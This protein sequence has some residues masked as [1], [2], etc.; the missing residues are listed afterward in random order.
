MISIIIPALNE[1]RTIA[2]VVA[3]CT[4]HPQV[5]EVVV[6]DD[7]SLDGTAARARAAG[8]K[9]ITSTLLGK[10]ASMRDGLL[11]AANDIIVFLDGDI[12]PYP[13]HTIDLLARS[14]MDGEADFVKSTFKRSAGR[15]TE[16]VAKPLLSMFFPG[17]CSFSQPLS[18]MIAGRREMF[19]KVNLANDY[20]VDIGILIDMHLQ[21][22]RIKEVDI[23]FI[24]NDSQPLQELGIMS[25]QVASAIIS[26]ATLSNS[27]TP[28]SFQEYRN[29]N[30]IRDQMELAFREQLVHEGKMV[31]FDMDDTILRGRFINAFTEKYGYTRQLEELRQK[32]RNP[33]ILTKAIARLLKGHHIGEL[34]AI[35]DSIPLVDDTIEVV[36]ELKVKGY[37]VGLITDSYDFVANHVKH[38]I[39]ADFCLANEAE[40]SKSV[41]TGEVKVPSFFFHNAESTC[42]HT[43]CKSNALKHVLNRYSIIHGNCIAVGDSENDICM[44]RQAG[45]GIAFCSSNS[46]L[47]SLADINIENRSFGQLLLC[48]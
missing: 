30:V 23:G 21:E 48:A 40:F 43:V 29:V 14:I 34:V 33:I 15:V 13:E 7:K 22:A 10:G 11:Y 38:R 4:R 35:A 32:H 12:H 44:I 6:V 5:T 24:E 36:A 1:E 19:S 20:G 25:R 26:R 46:Y 16:L 42:S 9:V 39:G 37:V 31:V 27:Q 28:V 2:E 8:A 41:A 3:F 47:K 18:G 17:L 45:T